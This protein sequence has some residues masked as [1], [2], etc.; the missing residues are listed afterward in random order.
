MNYNELKEQVDR[1]RKSVS[2]AKHEKKKIEEE[3][4]EVRESKHTIEVNFQR[5]TM[6][7]RNAAHDAYVAEAL[8]QY[9]DEI[10]VIQNNIN[11]NNDSY[12]QKLSELT[13]ENISDLYTGEQ[14]IMNE[15]KASL[16]VLQDILSKIISPRF[17]KELENQLDRQ[18]IN[19]DGQ[20]LEMLID[21]FNK[22]SYI[23][24]K[25]SKK[26]FKFDIMG[27]LNNQF[28][29]TNP[30]D[31][32]GNQESSIG[33]IDRSKL[34]IAVI[35]I[36]MITIT[37]LAAKY[38]FPI[39][40]VLLLVYSSYNIAKNYKIFSA[41]IAQKVIKDNIQQ[42]DDTLKQK[43]LTELERQKQ[44]LQNKHDET[45]K[46][47]QMQL[48]QKKTEMNNAAVNAEGTFVFDASNAQ[49]SY[50]AA[51]HAKENKEMSLVAQQKEIM[52]Q[53]EQLYKN[54]RESEDLLKSMVGSIQDQYLD[55]EKV[56]TS[57]IFEPVFI[58]DV[59]DN[60]PVFFE[61]PEQSVLFLYEEPVDVIDL[62][63]LLS[64]QLRIKLN[65]FNLNI[66]VIDQ[67]FMGTE[68]LI[69]QPVS[70]NADASIKNLYQILTAKEEV[71]ERLV[72]YNDDI[73]KRIRNIKRN[74]RNI[75]EYNN[76]ML[77]HDSLPESYDFL[78]YQDPGSDIAQNKIMQQL[79]INGSDVGIFPHL[80]IKS[81]DFYEMGDS[82]RK[83]VDYVGAIYLLREGEL[84]KRAK[85]FVLEKM[86][87]NSKS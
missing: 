12:M 30:L 8:K 20:N 66:T 67:V 10:A 50:E 87:K 63:R 60:K 44:E 47:L 39:Y 59:K 16:N 38:V 81:S 74:F 85:D 33:N 46:L 84:F 48:N 14:E 25:M 79:L 4:N 65:P 54:L 2:K 13:A 5:E 72:E 61:H 80:F 86:I 49:K 69:M 35:S 64:V 28:L 55:F 11:N 27:Y 9:E 1:N 52:D 82:A 62:V 24:D 29:A 57:V 40:L 58:F 3:L 41:I 32:I 51:M 19:L 53:L 34:N 17:Q 21:Y 22:Q 77:E 7:L 68:Y 42:V 76:Y 36:V 31:S 18:Q 6:N 70:D 37:V 45:D 83:L 26:S 73:L 56:G 23:I 43:V 15:I 71:D 78:F 75:K